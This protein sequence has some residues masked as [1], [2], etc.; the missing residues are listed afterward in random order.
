M[1]RRPAAQLTYPVIFE[2][3]GQAH[4]V[5]LRKPTAADLAALPVGISAALVAEKVSED[6]AADDEQAK[7]AKPAAGGALDKGIARLLSDVGKHIGDPKVCVGFVREGLGALA[8]RAQTAAAEQE[9]AARHL[10]LALAVE[11]DG[12][13]GTRIPFR[14]VRTETE[15]DA[16]PL[17]SY[18]I[19]RLPAV[20]GLWPRLREVILSAAPTFR[21]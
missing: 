3:D 1:L 7:P 19:D 5:Y 15:E 8:E 17:R 9:V 4:T 16:D 12:D 11:Q 2:I 10:L 18:W 14:F 6:A 20:R 13:D 21:S